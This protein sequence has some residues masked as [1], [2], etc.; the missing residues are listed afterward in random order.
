MDAIQL[1]DDW[2][3]PF[4]ETLTPLRGNP[5]TDAGNPERRQAREPVFR[6]CVLPFADL[7]AFTLL[8]NGGKRGVT[9]AVSALRSHVQPCHFLGNVE[10]ASL[11][12]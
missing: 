8:N 7:G 6:R 3:W 10:K 9:T 11:A 12:V 1:S 5:L 4:S 2:G